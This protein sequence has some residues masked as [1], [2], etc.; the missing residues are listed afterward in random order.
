[1]LLARPKL[2]VRPNYPTLAGDDSNEDIK[3]LNHEEIRQKA[4]RSRLMRLHQVF[5]K[6]LLSSVGLDR[7]LTIILDRPW[8]SR[9]G[10]GKMNFLPIRSRDTSSNRGVKDERE[11]ASRLSNEGVEYLGE[12]LKRLSDGQ[13][14]QEHHF[15]NQ[16]LFEDTQ[17]N[18]R[19]P[20]TFESR[21]SQD[22]R[23]TPWSDVS[24]TKPTGR[25]SANVVKTLRNNNALKSGTSEPKVPESRADIIA[26][27]MAN[28]FL[29]ELGQEIEQEGAVRKIAT[30]PKRKPLQDLGPHQNSEVNRARAINNL[31]VDQNTDF[32]A[33]EPNQ[34]EIDSPYTLTMKDPSGEIANSTNSQ[35]EINTPNSISI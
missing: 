29:A 6:L 26:L 10:K 14:Q 24:D 5:P 34:D 28:S 1:M 20:P 8:A 32:W 17:R 11:W 33:S 35:P 4:A 27:A 16:S 15:K 13:D 18:H 21:P 30:L 9:K 31:N 23:L 22:G 7:R 3:G 25:V 2:Q 12:R 19:S